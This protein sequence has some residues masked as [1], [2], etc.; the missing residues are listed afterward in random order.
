MNIKN[1]IDKLNL[2]MQA[3]VNELYSIKAEMTELFDTFKDRPDEE[4][5]IEIDKFNKMRIKFEKILI[6]IDPIVC[7]ILSNHDICKAID[8]LG[9]EVEVY[10]KSHADSKCQQD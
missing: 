2:K 9:V 10:E 3:K 8:K 5:K 7:M 1:T 4:N 6:E